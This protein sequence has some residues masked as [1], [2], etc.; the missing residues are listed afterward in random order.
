MPKQDNTVDKHLIMFKE[1]ILPHHTMFKGYSKEDQ[2]KVLKDIR[3]YGCIYNAEGLVEQ[4]MAII[5]GYKHVRAG[6]GFDFSDKSDAKTITL[7]EVTENRILTGTKREKIYTTIFAY[8]KNVHTKIG[9]LRV[10][11]FNA[12][13]NC[14]DY[15]YIP[16]SD[17]KGLTT[18]ASSVKKSDQI[19]ISY[20]K[21]ESY[22]IE[23]FRVAN[24]EEVARKR[25]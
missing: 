1:I 12:P 19:R 20:R 5:G 25:G 7:S 16:K 17:V 14:L 10:V 18:N 2:E 3:I 11:V 23:K 9:P 4:C 21:D 13:C 8:L 15:F 6:H 24:F 22:N